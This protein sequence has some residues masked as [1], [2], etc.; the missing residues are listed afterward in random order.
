MKKRMKKIL[1]LSSLLLFIQTRITTLQVDHRTKLSSIVDH[2]QFIVV[3]FYVFLVVSETWYNFSTLLA[4]FM[5][6]QTL[7]R[8]TSGHKCFIIITLWPQI[9]FL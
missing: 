1:T 7:S 6:T 8:F 5:P 4:T 2:L 9:F 3:N